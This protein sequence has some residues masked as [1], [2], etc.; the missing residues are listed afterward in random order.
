M[1]LKHITFTGVDEST[2]IAQ[3]QEIQKAFP[4]AEFGILTSYKWADNGPRYPS[5]DFIE[6]IRYKGLNLAL[7]V[8][9]KAAH[10]VSLKDGWDKYEKTLGKEVLT[11][12]KRIQINVGKRSDNPEYC[13]IP[14]VIGQEL[15]IQSNGADCTSL[16]ESTINHWASAP[17]PHRDTISTLIDPSGGRGQSSEIVLYKRPGFKRGYAGGINPTNVEEKLSYLLANESNPFWI[18]ME[19]GVRTDNLFDLNKVVQVLQ[20]CYK[21]LK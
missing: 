21:L 14:I 18:D 16:F 9:G 4:L 7:H 10:D 2:D 1:N 19:S 11:G 8:C 6:A 3:L 13:W 15:I 5:P 17:Y 12:F 20:T